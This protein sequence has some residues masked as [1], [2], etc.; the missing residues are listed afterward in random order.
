M[1]FPEFSPSAA[2]STLRSSVRS[3]SMGLKL[4]VVAFL[5]LTMTIPVLFV[6]GLVEERT[7]RAGDVMRE[8]SGHMGGQQTL[9]GP[10]LAIPY[11]VPA[12]LKG[13]VAQRGIYEVFPAQ[14]SAAVK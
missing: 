2:Q 12:Q 7:Q 4:I 14:A 10:T 8:I 9:L 1:D 11:I 6:G 13:E 5:A 3:R